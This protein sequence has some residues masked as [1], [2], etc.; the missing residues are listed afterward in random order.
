MAAADPAVAAVD[1]VADVAIAI[2]AVDPVLDAVVA[3]VDPVASDT[4]ASE[5]N[6]GTIKP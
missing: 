5:G 1:L 3:A 4:K 6:L 2:P